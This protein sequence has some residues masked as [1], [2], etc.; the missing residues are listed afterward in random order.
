M[1]PA[2]LGEL[3]EQGRGLPDVRVKDGHVEWSRKVTLDLDKP[4]PVDLA[5]LL[6]EE[7]KLLEQPVEVTGLP[8]AAM[9]MKSYQIRRHG[10]TPL[11]KKEIDAPTR[12]YAPLSGTDLR[13]WRSLSR[14]TCA[15]SA[16]RG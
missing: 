12:V 3:A 15:T 9:I 5:T 11:E 10:Y 2:Q 4:R 16:T 1:S 7:K 6:R 8:M 14:W 13:V